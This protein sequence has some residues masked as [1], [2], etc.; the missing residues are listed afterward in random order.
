MKLRPAQNARYN[1]REELQTNINN[2]ILGLET[3]SLTASLRTTPMIEIKSLNHL[4][5]LHST[6][7]NVIDFYAD[8]SKLQL[9]HSSAD[10]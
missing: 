2:F 7:L 3:L 4:S 1:Q 10:R 8:V 5:S 6:Q 9:F